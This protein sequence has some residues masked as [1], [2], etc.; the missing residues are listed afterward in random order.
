M[1]AKRQIHI[2]RKALLYIH[3]NMQQQQQLL[4]NVIKVS[5]TMA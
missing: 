2:A 5:A 3:I 1:T 4:H